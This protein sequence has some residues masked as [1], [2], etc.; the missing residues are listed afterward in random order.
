MAVEDS[1]IS[2]AS[3]LHPLNHR[4]FK[5]AIEAWSQR[6]LMPRTNADNEEHVS[7]HDPMESGYS[8]GDVSDRWSRSGIDMA[9]PEAVMAS[10]RESGGPRPESTSPNEALRENLSW[11]LTS[12]NVPHSTFSTHSGT[13]SGL[14]HTGVLM[15]VEDDEGNRTVMAVNPHLHAS[16]QSIPLYEPY[17]DHKNRL[18]G[19]G[20]TIDD[21]GVD[22]SKFER[23]R[24]NEIHESAGGKP[25][26]E[27]SGNAGVMISGFPDVESYSSLLRRG[28]PVRNSRSDIFHDSHGL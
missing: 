11:H 15:N 23:E 4:L 25:P 3:E 18:A 7:F 17:E 6:G 21:W 26:T 22:Q 12:E 2:D 9:T 24:M 28:Y 5:G 14:Q 27:L 13:K 8:E 19:M 10:S 20:M 1:F 16:D